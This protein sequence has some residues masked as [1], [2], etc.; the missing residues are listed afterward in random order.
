MTLSNSAA[1][2]SYEQQKAQWD[3]QGAGDTSGQMIRIEAENASKTSSQMLYPTQDQSSP[4]VYPSSAKELLNNAIGGNS[5]RLVN[6]WIEWN[7]DVPEDGYYYVTLHARQNFVKGVYV[8]RK[9]SID[10]EVP[11]SE[12]SDY[13]FHM[14]RTGGWIRFQMMKEMHTGYI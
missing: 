11:F 4:A 10:G 2:L 6:Q 13:G 5:W 1:T 12:L 14:S 3:S 9:I 7:F 8:S